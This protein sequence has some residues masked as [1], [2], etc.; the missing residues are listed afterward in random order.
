MVRN[1]AGD[2]QKPGLVVGEVGEEL[3]DRSKI[4]ERTSTKLA[5][6]DLEHGTLGRTV[7]AVLAAKLRVLRATVFVVSESTAQEP[8]GDEEFPASSSDTV[9]RVNTSSATCWVQPGLKFRSRNW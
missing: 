3:R 6:V 5:V 8:C 1:A 4:V 2:G 7:A 9:E